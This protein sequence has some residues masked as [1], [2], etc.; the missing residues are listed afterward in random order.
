MIQVENLLSIGDRVLSEN[1]FEQKMRLGRLYDFYGGLLTERQQKCM[2]MHFY[3]D[4][5]LAEIADEFGVSRQAIHDL[6]KRVEQT[7]E[8]YENRLGLLARNDVEQERL[9]KIKDLLIEYIKDNSKQDNL[10]RMSQLLQEVS[11]EGR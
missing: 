5:S 4:L 9:F 11:S 8:K 1:V 10:E 6:L 2:E 7:L 3:E